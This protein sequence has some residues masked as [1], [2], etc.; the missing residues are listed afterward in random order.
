[1]RKGEVRRQAI[2][3][4]ANALFCSK[5]YLETT[6]DDILEELHCSK[7]S[8]YH[9]FDSKLSVL[10]AICESRVQQSF[11]MYRQTRV[12]STRE[13]L[14]SLLYWAQPFRP[15]NEEWLVLTLRLRQRGEGL[16]LD[17]AMRQAQRQLFKPEMENLML[18]LNETGAAHISRP[19]LEDVTFEAFTAFCDE[20]NEA[21]V[22]C[23]RQGRSVVTDVTQVAEAARFL[24][25]R[26]LDMDYGCMELVRLSEMLP[27]L[28]RVA[29]RLRE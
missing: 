11:E 3:D 20:M 26:V 21:I 19:R 14:N 9:Y 25:E 5:G 13:K 7:G 8:F 12:T 24:W 28:E 22:Q 18:I 23:A 17:G 15:E 27:V 4:A 1:M 16:V 10:Q 2:V 6:V 29:S